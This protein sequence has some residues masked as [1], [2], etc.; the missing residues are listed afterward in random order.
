M[1]RR[2]VTHAMAGGAVALLLPLAAADVPSDSNQLELPPEMA[3]Q[4][5]K[6]KDEKKKKDEL[7]KFEDVAKDYKKVVSTADGDGLIHEEVTA[8]EIAEVLSKWT[9]IPVAKMLEAQREKLLHMEDR[10]GE[11]VVGQEALGEAVQRLDGGGVY[12]G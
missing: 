5:A 4:M 12:L 7:P 8:E 9:G 11:R 2:K 1:K 10:I 3:A 6:S